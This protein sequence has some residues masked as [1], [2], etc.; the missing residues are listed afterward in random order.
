[1]RKHCRGLADLERF[2]FPFFDMRYP[3]ALLRLCLTGFAPHLIS[4]RRFRLRDE[5]GYAFRS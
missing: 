4:S 2:V 1:M 3:A 5:A